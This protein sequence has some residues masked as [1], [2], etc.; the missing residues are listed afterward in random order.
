MGRLDQQGPQFVVAGLNHSRIGLPLAAGHVP[1]TEPDEAGQL[2]A[3]TKAVE[4]ADLCSQRRGGHQTNAFDGQ[5][6]FHQWIVAGL[7]FQPLIDLAKLLWQVLQPSQP[8]LGDV[9]GAL[10]LSSAL[11]SSQASQA[12]VQGFTWQGA[13]CRAS[14]SAAPICSFRFLRSLVSD[15]R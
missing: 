1:G 14:R 2:F 4:P 12:L 13:F 7:T 10:G 5:Q 15:W 9:A 3:R 11:A 6:L 8:A